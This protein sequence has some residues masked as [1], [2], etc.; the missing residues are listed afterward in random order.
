MSDIDI[1]ET[2]HEV[3]KRAKQ[4]PEPKGYHLLCMVPKVD[5]EYAGGIVK[6]DETVRV[7][8]Q[9]TIVLFVAK[10]GPDAYRDEKRFPSGPY[11]KQ[12]DFV[13]VRPYAGTRLKLYGTEWRLINDDS[14]EATV[15]DPRGLSRA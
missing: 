8:E 1:D 10:M 4:L 12:G 7:E 6:S 9:T 5:S 13:L 14:V 3:D 15:E 11:C 2:V